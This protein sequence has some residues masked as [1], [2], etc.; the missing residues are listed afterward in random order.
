MEVGLEFEQSQPLLTTF[1]TAT[2]TV[3][4]R[5]FSNPIYAQSWRMRTKL[6]MRANIKMNSRLNIDKYLYNELIF[7]LDE[8]IAYLFGDIYVIYKNSDITYFQTTNP[9][10]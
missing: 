4:S 6:K 1:T 10:D 5:I 2:G 8:L 7:E 9:I 3:G